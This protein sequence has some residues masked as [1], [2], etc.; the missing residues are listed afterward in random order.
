MKLTELKLIHPETKQDDLR[1]KIIL[2]FRLAS[3]DAD[4]VASFLLG[5]KDWEDLSTPARSKI[6]SYYENHPSKNKDPISLLKGDF[7]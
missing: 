5:I 3:N 2:Q 7:L 4:A 6:F 1:K